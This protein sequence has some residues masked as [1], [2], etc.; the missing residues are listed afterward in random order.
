MFKPDV[1]H[2]EADLLASFAILGNGGLERTPAE[3]GGIKTGQ[4]R[5]RRSRGFEEDAPATSDARST[6]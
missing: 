1:P 6:L 2:A 4:Y 5:P 3:A